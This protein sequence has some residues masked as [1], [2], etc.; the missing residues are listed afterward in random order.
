MSGLVKGV[1]KV[2]KKVSKVVKKIAVPLLVVG[3][4]V[5]T[6]GAALGLPAMA[7]GW[8]ARLQAS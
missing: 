1:K 8:G 4:V 5:F 3:A 6:A 2:F 7:G